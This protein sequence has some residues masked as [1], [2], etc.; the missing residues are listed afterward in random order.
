MATKKSDYPSSGLF[1]INFHLKNIYQEEKKPGYINMLS[2][3]VVHCPKFN[4][5]SLPCSTQT[6]KYLKLLFVCC[7]FLFI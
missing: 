6:P 1:Y 7:H 3:I 2:T 5:K 4:H